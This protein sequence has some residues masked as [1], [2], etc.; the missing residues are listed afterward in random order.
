[1]RLGFYIAGLALT[2]I[3]SVSC[4]KAVIDPD[5]ANGNTG[6][7]NLPDTAVYDPDVRNIMFNNCV[8]CHGGS[9]PSAGLDLTNYTNVRQATEVGNL[10]QRM[11]STTSPMPPAGVL[12]QEMRSTVEK[13]MNDGYP[14]N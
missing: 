4:T 5:A 9:A 6:Q 13:W 11:N 10:F 14:E 2:G 8:T 1:M 3:I 12:P 7:P